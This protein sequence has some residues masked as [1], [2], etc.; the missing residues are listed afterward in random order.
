MQNAAFAEPR[1]P[2]DSHLLATED[3]ALLKNFLFFF[4]LLCLFA[5]SCDLCTPQQQVQLVGR[6]SQKLWCHDFDSSH[7]QAQ[8][9]NRTV[10]SWTRKHAQWTKSWK[11][12]M[13][14]APNWDPMCYKTARYDNRN[15]SCVCLLMSTSVNMI[16]TCIDE[17][18]HKDE[19]LCH[20]VAEINLASIAPPVV[21]FS[22]PSMSLKW[23]TTDSRF[24]FCWDCIKEVDVASGCEKLSHWNVPL[25]C[26]I[27]SWPAG[28]W[29]PL[30]FR[31]RRRW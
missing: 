5:T 2:S 9:H 30:A 31:R 19:P 25:T 28:L 21:S 7:D 8:Y 17:V 18:V 29:P 26:I 11:V 1:N 15:A 14:V 10:N 6:I 20:S 13:K 24:V 16:Y 12:H 27:F 4:F 22:S 3:N 23:I